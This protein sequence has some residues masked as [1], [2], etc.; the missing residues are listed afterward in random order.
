[1]KKTTLMVSNKEKDKFISKLRKAGVL[2]IRHISKPSA[3]QISFAEDRLAKI[4]RFIEALEP[5]EKQVGAS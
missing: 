1:M 4:D 2:H 3:H 5:Y